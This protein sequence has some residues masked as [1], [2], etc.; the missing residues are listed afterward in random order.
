MLGRVS[1][2]QVRSAPK[3]RTSAAPRRFTAQAVRRRRV[4]AVGVLTLSLVTGLV[5]WRARGAGSPDGAALATSEGPSAPTSGQ[6]ALTGDGNP[7][8]QRGSGSF[9]VAP[10]SVPAPGSGALLTVRV[11]V[12]HATGYP[13]HEFA[14]AVMRT[15]ND[16]RSWGSGGAR[17]F[18][19]TD[20]PAD[21]AVLLASP[22]TSA[23]LCR[24]LVTRGTLSCSIGNR[25]IITTHRWAG[26]TPEFTDLG[27][28]R[29]YVVNHEVGHVLGQGHRPCAGPG[30]LAAVMQQQT[31]KVAPCAPNAWPD[32]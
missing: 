16:P 10:G 11:E 27:V 15:L 23:A 32:P 13:A 21:I 4:V 19:R 20:G 28:Y 25:A 2:R 5:S 8:V 24:P 26:G 6:P 14:D 18:A 3:G 17:S 1:D 7:V 29:Q 31:I 30:Q 12:E 22:D 9:T